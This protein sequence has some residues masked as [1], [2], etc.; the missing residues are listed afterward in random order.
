V[1]ESEGRLYE[2]LYTLINAKILR[3]EMAAEG[4]FVV[5]EHQ[6]DFSITLLVNLFTKVRELTQHP[7]GAT[8]PSMKQVAGDDQPAGFVRRDEIRQ[9]LE[10]LLGRALWHGQPRP[11]KRR[12]L[13]EMQIGT[14]QR[15]RRRQQRRPAR[16]KDDVS[17]V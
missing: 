1:D 14:D 9:P 10:I 12:R 17:V 11:A 8:G 4:S 2:F 15:L 7:R 13:A 6:Y 16:E 5:A 3:D